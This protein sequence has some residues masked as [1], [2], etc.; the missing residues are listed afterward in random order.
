MERSPVTQSGMRAVVG[1]A[2]AVVL[3]RTAYAAEADLVARATVAVTAFVHQFS[4]LVAEERYIQE[5]RTPRGRRELTSDFLLVQPAGSNEWFQFRDVFEVDGHRLGN[6]AERL[7]QL[8]LESPGDVIARAREIAHD[9]ERFNLEKIGTLNQ[10][11]IALSF[12]Q[13]AYVSH[14][15]FTVG[16]LDNAEGPGIRVVQ[17]REQRRPTILQSGQANGDLPARGRWWIEERTGRVMKTE[18]VVGGGTSTV[19]HFRFDDDLHVMVP[20]DMRDSYTLGWTE[21]TGVATYGRFRRFQVRTD[22]TLNP[23]PPAANGTIPR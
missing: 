10:P 17:Y 19:T 14:F 6:R 21:L 11:L 20:V 1:A 7:T 16:P 9:G 15:T 13:P 4:N 2:M 12:L 5:R 18:L 22:E 3:L 23:Q 8:F